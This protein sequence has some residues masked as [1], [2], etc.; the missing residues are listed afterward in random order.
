M[1]VLRD[2]PEEWI[3]R[4]LNDLL[5][6]SAEMKESP[7][8]FG[9][10]SVLTKVVQSSNSYDIQVDNIGFNNRVVE[11]VY[12]PSTVAVDAQ[13]TILSFWYTESYA[14]SANTAEVLPDELGRS[15]NG[16]QKFRLYLR[17]NDSNPPVWARY[18]FYFETI[19]S[20]TFTASLL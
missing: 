18:K 8:S 3:N 14:S 7:Q 17:G 1:K 16:V 10:E 2:Q 20:G 4:D 13:G 9:S 6:T 11:V 5:Y 19:G 15:A 12:T